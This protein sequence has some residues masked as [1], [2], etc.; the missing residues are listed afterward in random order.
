[1]LADSAA[2][3]EMSNGLEEVEAWL[4]TCSDDS[5]IENSDLKRLKSALAACTMPPGKERRLEVQNL[6][7]PTEWSVTQKTQGVKRT[8][9]QLHSA[10]V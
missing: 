4:A 2:K 10:L 1:M 3:P 9:E 7:R 8:A 5:A 6:S